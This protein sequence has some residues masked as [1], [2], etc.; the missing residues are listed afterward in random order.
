MEWNRGRMWSP[1][2]TI[3]PLSLACVAPIWVAAGGLDLRMQFCGRRSEQPYQVA[4]G[5][6]Q[7]K[8]MNVPLPHTKLLLPPNLVKCPC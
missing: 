5:L 6:L 4:C 7:D 2:A 3:R 1:D 8:G